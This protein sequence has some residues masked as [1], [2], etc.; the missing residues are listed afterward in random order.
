[1]RIAAVQHDIVWDDREANFA[2]LAPMIAAAAAG[3]ARLV[4]LTE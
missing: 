2:R 3:S 4:L 1:M